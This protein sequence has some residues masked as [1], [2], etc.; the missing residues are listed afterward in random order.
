[1]AEYD[2]HCGETCLFSLV[3]NLIGAAFGWMLLILM[4]ESDF[5]PRPVTA[6]QCFLWLNLIDTPC[7]WTCF[8][9]MVGPFIWIRFSIFMVESRQSFCRF[10]GFNIWQMAVKW[11]IQ[12]VFRY[13][14]LLQM[15]ENQYKG[16][17]YST[18]FV[19]VNRTKMC[20]APTRNIR[21]ILVWNWFTVTL[22]CSAEHISNK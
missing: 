20:T 10:C 3:L 5:Y 17:Y 18:Y 9:L 22:P 7:G 1:M 15:I 14:I 16:V 4:A 6:E 21:Y 2:A 8:F 12:I 19:L 13:Q 11:Q